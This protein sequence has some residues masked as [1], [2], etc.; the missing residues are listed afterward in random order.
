MF[1]LVTIS[2]QSFRSAAAFFLTTCRDRTRCA[3]SFVQTGEN[4]RVACIL[5]FLLQYYIVYNIPQRCLLIQVLVLRHSGDTVS[6][7]DFYERLDLAE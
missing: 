7:K 6:S 2:A 4:K 5:W 3:S 1:V